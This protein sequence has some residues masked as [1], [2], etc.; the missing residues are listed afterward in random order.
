MLRAL[1]V[2][3]PPQWQV[4]L[5]G[6]A[7]FGS[8]FLLSWAAELAQLEVPQSLAIAGV[9]LLAVLPEYAVD[10]Y[11][12]WMAGKDPAYTGYAMANM[13]GANRLLIGVGWTAVVLFFWLKTRI[14]QITLESFR[15][16]DLLAL[17]VATLYSF[18][19]VVK[20]DL[21]LFDTVALLGIFVFYII[22][23]ARGELSHPAL[24]EGPA[25]LIGALPAVARR[26]LTIVMFVYAGTGIF[27]AAEPFAEG[28]LAT[29]KSFGIEEFLLVQWL[30][31]L[32]S[33]APE[34]IIALL[35][36][37]R[38][39]PGAGIGTLIS[40]KVNQWTLLVGMLPLVYAISGKTFGAMHLDTRQVEELLL[41]AAQSFLAVIILANL[42]FSIRE[43]IALFMLFVTQLVIPH[44]TV[45]YAYSFLYL[46]LGIGFLA[47]YKD[48]RNLFLA[49]FYR[50]LPPKACK[51]KTHHPPA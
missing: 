10:F 7:I 11:F 28:L 26:F 42:S 16:K 6:L 37:A 19:I 9:A 8:A 25:A 35:F 38:M 17:T 20:G 23:V 14:R 45:H 31:P 24:G 33:E 47:V 41:T 27:L 13:T 12:A 21:S 50:L 3:L 44:P 49:R 32:A 4:C 43:G 40:S 2:A 39:N 22:S 46:L 48:N 36:V 18:V 5:T 1:G 29:G 51:Q 15:E 34:F 30:A